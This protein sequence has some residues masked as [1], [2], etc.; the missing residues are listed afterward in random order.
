MSEPKKLDFDSY[1]IADINEASLA[2]CIHIMHLE[3]DHSISNN[4]KYDTNEPYMQSSEYYA[5]YE[6]I[7]NI[8]TTTN[9]YMVSTGDNNGTST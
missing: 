8:M 3:Y 6:R 7:N 2:E 1:D 4:L 9:I 5:A